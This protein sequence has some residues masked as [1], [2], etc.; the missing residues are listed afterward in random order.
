MES[1]FYMTDKCNELVVVFGG[2]I[3][4]CTCVPKDESDKSAHILFRELNKKTN[5]GV[6]NPEE[7]NFDGPSI[8]FVF[9]DARSVDVVVNHLLEVKKQLER[10][11]DSKRENK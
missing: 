5:I 9:E 6:R 3:G 10:I 2:K 7:W 8:H 4:V 1:G 11:A